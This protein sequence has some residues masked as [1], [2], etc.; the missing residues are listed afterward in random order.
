MEA[1]AEVA[2]ALRII[3]SKSSGPLKSEKAIWLSWVG[4]FCSGV[5]EIPTLRKISST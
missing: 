4:V 2:P 3:S 5:V 1:G